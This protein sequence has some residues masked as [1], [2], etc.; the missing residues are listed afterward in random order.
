MMENKFHSIPC[1]FPNS[2]KI[3]SRHPLCHNPCHK[4]SCSHLLFLHCSN[5]NMLQKCRFHKK[6][7]PVQCYRVSGTRRIS[8]LRYSE[9]SNLLVKRWVSEN[10]WSSFCFFYFHHCSQTNWTGSSC[11]FFEKQELITFCDL[12]QH[13]WPH[14][15]FHWYYS[16][17]HDHF[18]SC[19]FLPR[20][21]PVLK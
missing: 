12:Q 8:T 5:S 13:V 11:A 16:D 1:K 9:H 20:S 10:M 14:C 2:L 15:G 4:D 18:L 3:H 21:V 17:L 6:L 19:Q 7:V